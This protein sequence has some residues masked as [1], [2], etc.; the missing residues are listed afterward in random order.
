MGRLL[1]FL[2]A[3]ASLT[4]AGVFTN[5]GLEAKATGGAIA[6]D[7]LAGIVAE[8]LSAAG[9]NEA[10][11]SL[12]GLTAVPAVVTTLTGQ[13]PGGTYTAT[14]RP[15]P[16]DQVVVTV[17]GTVLGA[18]R[19]GE[20]THTREAT[21][22]LESGGAPAVPAFLGQ[23]M[24]IERTLTMNT[25]QRVLSGDP[26]VNANIHVNDGS[27]LNLSWHAGI[28]GF[29]QSPTPPPHSWMYDLLRSSFVPNANPENLD[30][31]QTV[32]PIDIPVVDAAAMME[33]AG[34]DATD[35]AWDFDPTRPVPCYEAS[36]PRAA[37]CKN[38]YTSTNVQPL[39]GVL[40]FTSS[41]TAESPA[42]WVIRGDFNLNSNR[43]LVVQG[44]VNI[45][46][47][48]NI[49]IHGA[50]RTAA[51]STLSLYSERDISING[52]S[53]ITGS[54]MN[55]NQWGGNIQFSDNTII[56]GPVSTR[57]T[58]NFNGNSKIVYT[59]LSGH[60]TA[61]LFGGGSGTATG[62]RPVSVRA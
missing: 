16:P 13:M 57:G 28:Q 2:V 34:I 18:G 23:A 41:S 49:N 32:D 54:V 15:A 47:T 7:R 55:G 4:T 45:V 11:Q 39:G 27:S 52:S 9:L 51:G 24:T 14:L 36:S 19:T 48:G 50:I 37:P 35:D 29:Y 44:H 38:A 22:A 53:D 6:Q 40:D 46:T 62:F 25:A 21:F 20:A 43:T 17:V 58:I 31:W 33:Q 5:R 60:M 3:A 10:A 12:A 8:R 30:V 26:T 59:P 56:R 61:P 42:T 1:L